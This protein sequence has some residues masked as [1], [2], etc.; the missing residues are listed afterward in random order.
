MGGFAEG[1]SPMVSLEPITLSLHT[2]IN[3]YPDPSDWPQT[4]SSDR[5]KV[6]TTMGQRP[7][8]TPVYAN[9]RLRMLSASRQVRRARKSPS[10]K[11][12]HSSPIRMPK[13]QRSFAY[14][15]PP[16]TELAVVAQM[17]ALDVQCK[18]RF[19]TAA[20]LDSLC[21]II[22][23]LRRAMGLPPHSH[24]IEAC[25]R[26]AES[27]A[28]SLYDYTDYSWDVDAE[29]S[30]FRN[31][32]ESADDTIEGRESLLFTLDCL[33]ESLFARFKRT[34]NLC[35][36][37]EAISTDRKAVELTPEGHIDA[38]LRLCNLGNSL[39]T[40][41][42]RTGGIQDIDEAILSERD[43]ALLERKALELMPD[44]HADLPI[45]LAN[46]GDSLSVQF[47]RTG[48]IEHLN[49]AILLEKKALE[50]TPDNHPNL[51]IRLSNLGR[52]LLSQFKHSGSVGY[53]D[54]AILS[55]RR[56][57]E[58]APVGST[59]LPHWLW[60]LGQSLSARFLHVRNSSNFSKAEINLCD[61][62]DIDEAIAVTEEAVQL[63]PNGHTI[64]PQYIYFLGHH[65]H[66]RSALP[67]F[68][69]DIATCIDH[70]KRAAT[71][72]FGHPESRLGSALSLARLRSKHDP[73]S[74]DVTLALDIALQ[75]TLLLAGLEQTIHSRYS[76]LQ[77]LSDLPLEAAA[78]GISAKQPAKALEWLEQGRC[79]VWGQL[80]SLRTPFD[81]LELH[82]GELARQIREV[83]KQ[84][85][86]AASTRQAPHWGTSM[87]QKISLEDEAR[88]HLRLARRWDGLLE[89]V[90]DVPGFEEFL[91]PLPCATIL[92]HLPLSGHVIVIN[93][94]KERCD[95]LALT[96]GMNEPLHVTLPQFSAEK[97]ARY[98]KDI[99][100]RLRAQGFR[101]REEMMD[102]VDCGPARA[103]GPYRRKQMSD[104][105]VLLGVLG[106]L[107]NEVVKP[108]LD[109]L[110]L[111][112]VDQTSSKEI[113]RIWWCP[114]GP[115]SFLP[116][117]AAGSYGTSE[118]EGVFHYAISSYTPTVTALT[119][120]VR[121]AQASAED[122][123]GAG[124][125]LTS[126]PNAVPSCRIPGTTK[127]VTGIC[128]SAGEHGIK[129]LHLDGGDVT[130]EQCL[131][132]M[133]NFRSLELGTILQRNLKDAD[134][135]FLSACQTSTGD[136]MLP[137]EAVHLAAGMLAAGYR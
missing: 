42:V 100:A 97:A 81:E 87:A 82:N 28:D 119:Q 79:L 125:F 69:E 13:A 24:V 105:D 44:G 58:L 116:L 136:D 99:T 109:A 70:F 71:C 17:E 62:H 122:M 129:V 104:R 74:P 32:V 16:L 137:D 61:S 108:I 96:H 29:I 84:L 34:S 134:L 103:G 37:N 54:E 4:I 86:D 89:T 35:D 106:G 60:T 91:R 39:R 41:F 77:S 133:E 27:S 78:L 121:D 20:S 127:E 31:A 33:G 130:V 18:K 8:P 9:R 46:L 65:F 98:R 95:A 15:Q 88:S 85:E 5:E 75:V 6:P 113:P 40:R 10:S 23:R 76:Q 22:S 52:S 83:A 56:A 120:R 64:L 102:E 112:R 73:Q 2:T 63:S 25:S 7:H 72:K 93:V 1:V 14:A 66:S 135:A 94:H 115:L 57:V 50:L 26:D 92:R 3:V 48:N 131:A 53:L 101:V 124:I 38:P 90:R 11:G 43:R 59:N 21:E 30:A 118:P 128:E 36:L 55:Q 111:S 126:Q 117:H 19:K 123:S 114:T 68:E 12:Q 132:H 107:W 80:N 49:E 45:R 67:G 47:E 51:P 110:E